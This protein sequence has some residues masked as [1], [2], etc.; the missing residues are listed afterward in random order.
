L[1]DTAVAVHPD[2]ARYRHLIGKRIRLP[3]T[4]RD[5]PIVGDAILVDLAF[6]TGAVKITPAHDFNDYDAGERHQLPRVAIFD[7]QALLD[8]ASL[9]SA[10]VEE[11]IITAV[12]RLPVTKARPKIEQA[13]KDRS[14]LVKVEDHK[15]ALGKCYR[16]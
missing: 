7:H 8:P 5:V 11:D 6:G 1:G 9:A 3:L 16:C 10:E 15:M 2:D 14:L 12:G 4:R 13:L